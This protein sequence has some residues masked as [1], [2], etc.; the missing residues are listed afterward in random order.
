MVISASASNNNWSLLF[1]FLLSVSSRS[2][3]FYPS[4][5]FIVV[6]YCCIVNHPEISGINTFYCFSWY[7]ALI[8]SSYASQVVSWEV[9]MARRVEMTSVTW[10]PSWC[11]CWC[12]LLP[13]SSA[14]TADQSLY[15]SPCDFSMWLSWVPSYHGGLMV[16]KVFTRSWLPRPQK[17]THLCFTY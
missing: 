12:W 7:C 17:R 14:R 8:G 9:G 4:H 2:F 13:R 6:I 10:L 1:Q 16:V 3:S 11:Y 5:N 15:F